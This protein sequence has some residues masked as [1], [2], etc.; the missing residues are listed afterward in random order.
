[1]PSDKCPAY[2]QRACVELCSRDPVMA[3]LIKRFRHSYLSG[4]R[5]AFTTLCRA[6]VGQQISLQAADSI[7]QRLEAHFGT[8]K[9]TAIHYCHFKT[10]RQCG[11]SAQKAQYLKNIARFFVHGKIVPAYWRRREFKELQSTLLA[12]KGVGEWTFQMFAIFYLKYPDIL[13][14]GDLG[15]LNAIYKE[16]NH[17]KKLPTKNL[18]KITTRWQPWRTVATWYLWRSIDPEPVVY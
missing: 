1:M 10:L 12:I 17:G 18:Y 2:W 8:L 16:Y 7:W 14:L 11:L 6:V 15:L 4:G 9:P 3:S 5:D 13:P